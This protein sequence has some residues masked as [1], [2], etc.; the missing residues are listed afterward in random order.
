MKWQRKR[1]LQAE[2]CTILV[3]DR[4]TPIYPLGLSRIHTIDDLVRAMGSTACTARKIGDAADVLEPMARDKDCFVVMTLSGGL[5][6]GKMGLIFCDLV[7]SGIVKAIVSTDALM[8]HGLVEATGRSHFRYDEK[9]A[10]GVCRRLQLRLRFTR[11]RIEPGSRR[12]SHAA[13]C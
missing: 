2:F 9:L 3:A 1:A 8:V 5:T 12:G 4:L 6:V 11:A 10:G 7:D 13:S